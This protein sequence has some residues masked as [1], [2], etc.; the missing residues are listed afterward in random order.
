MAKGKTVKSYKLITKAKPMYSRCKFVNGARVSDTPVEFNGNMF[1]T[2]DPA[3]QEFM[4]N[5]QDNGKLFKCVQERKVDAPKQVE[6]EPQ[7]STTDIET[8]TVKT[9][10]EANEL[11][12]SKGAD[13]KS[14]RS[15]AD[16]IAAGKEYGIDIQ[17]G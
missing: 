8:I 6:Y 17:Q 10:N 7:D 13:V 3:L 12:K 11:L 9:L 4:D 16:V 15:W 2:S 5:H 14:K 1:I